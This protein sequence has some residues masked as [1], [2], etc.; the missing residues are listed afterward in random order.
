M[1]VIDAVRRWSTTRRMRR[2]MASQAGELAKWEAAGRPVPPPAFAK[3]RVIRE[4]AVRSGARALVETGTFYG[5]TTFALRSDFDRIDTIEL[6]E[7][8]FRKARKRLAGWR[9]I[10]AWHGDSAT[11]LPEV[12]A[13]FDEPAVFWLDAHYSEGVTA[14][15]ESDTPIVRELELILAHPVA[16][17]VLLIDDA[18]CF[19]GEGGYPTLDEVRA[20]VARKRPGLA[21]EVE[22]DIIRVRL[23]RES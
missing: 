8:L 14:R 11:V 17:H 4:Y 9:H 10:R 12:L 22:D 21:L 13:T 16:G 23:K 7:D 2:W 5:Q 15:G 20:L 18:R 19:V 1:S 3:H 6:S